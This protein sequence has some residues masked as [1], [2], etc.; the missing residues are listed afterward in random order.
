MLSTCKK[1]RYSLLHQL[2]CLNIF[3]SVGDD[4]SLSFSELKSTVMESI[5]EYIDEIEVSIHSISTQ[6]KNSVC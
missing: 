3:C 4:Y 6:V 1:S 5:K 2:Q